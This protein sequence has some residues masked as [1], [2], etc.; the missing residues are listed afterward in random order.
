MKS[1]SSFYS[2]TFWFYFSNIFWEA[3][4]LEK[5]DID[6]ASDR[7]NNTII[8]QTMCLRSLR[9]DKN[10]K[11][12][13]FSWLPKALKPVFFIVFFSIFGSFPPWNVSQ[14]A[15]KFFWRAFH[16]K[17]LEENVKR[18]WCFYKI[19]RWGRYYYRVFP[20]KLSAV[21]GTS[22]ATHFPLEKTVGNRVRNLGELFLFKITT[23]VFLILMKINILWDSWKYIEFWN[24]LKFNKFKNFE[25]SQFYWNFAN[26][27]DFLNFL[28]FLN[29]TN[30][31]K[32]TNFSNF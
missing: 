14:V 22:C 23:E 19:S 5:M 28:T 9:L 15:H 13:I 25:V 10:R 6:F 18:F 11:C 1:L 27:L 2:C 32:K 8:S 20:I 24:F 7:L 31:W 17:F 3:E 12:M 4:Q 29:C 21:F 16:L 26:H 30:V